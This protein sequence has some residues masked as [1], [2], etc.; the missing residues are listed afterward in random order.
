MKKLIS[1]AI[2]SFAG[3]VNAGEVTASYLTDSGRDGYAIST[4]VKGVTLGASHVDRVY[5][6][7][8]VGKS[9]DVA[10]MGPLQL[11]AGGSAVYQNTLAKN[12]S[13]YGLVAQA[14][15]T[16]AV[17]KNVD[18]VAGVQKFW[19]QDRVSAQNGNSA[20]VGIKVKF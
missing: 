11:A 9:F 1:I 8:S 15:A 2:I 4:Q 14:T 16:A 5:D 18:V 6:R 10:K 13:G 20:T 17:N 19:G 7:F 12:D 3:V